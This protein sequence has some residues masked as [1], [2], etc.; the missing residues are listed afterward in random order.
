MRVDIHVKYVGCSPYFGC[1][2]LFG[3][4]FLKLILMVCLFRTNV[5]HCLEIDVYRILILTSSS[6][7]S[8]QLNSSKNSS[9]VSHLLFHWPGKKNITNIDYLDFILATKRYLIVLSLL[10]KLIACTIL[11]EPRLFL[12]LY[13][14]LPYKEENFGHF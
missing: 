1:S 10:H 2:A 14:L 12:I 4:I 13:F 5:H 8:Q 3:N 11:F 7:N 6:S 9:T